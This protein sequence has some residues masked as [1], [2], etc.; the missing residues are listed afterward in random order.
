M[1]SRPAVDLNGSAVAARSA[2]RPREDMRPSPARTRPLHSAQPWRPPG[3]RKGSFTLA[4]LSSC[5]LSLTTTR[6][7][8]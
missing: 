3:R 7:T 4:Q 6:E 8:R 5:A 1:R 2:A